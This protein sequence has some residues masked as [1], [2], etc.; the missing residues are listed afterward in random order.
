MTPGLLT[1][2]GGIGLFLFGMQTMTDALRQLASTQAR[3]V[4]ARFTRTPASGALTGALTTAA[5]QSSTATMVTTVGFVGAGLLS[6]SQALGIIF[7]ASVGTTVTGWMV[8]F[9]G[10]RLPLSAAAL[11]VLFAAALLRVL[12]NGQTARAALAVAGLC[13]V[14]LGIDLMQTGMEAYEGRL[15]PADFPPASFFGRLQLVAIGIVVTLITQSSS[16]GVAGTLVL[17]AGGAVSFEQAAALVIGMHVGTTFTALL[18]SVG[19]SLAVRRTAVANVVYHVASGAIALLFIDLVAAGLARG[20]LFGDSQIGL[21]VFHTGFNLIGTAVM[22]PITAQFAALIERMIPERLTASL[23]DR[24]DPRLLGEAGAALDTAGSVLREATDR[25]FTALADEMGPEPPAP[26]AME[27]VRQ[28]LEPVLDAMQDYLGRIEVDRDRV[29]DLQ[30]LDALLQQHDHLRRLHARAAQG[31]RIRAL[32]RQERL[33]RHVGVFRGCL[34]RHVAEHPEGAGLAH[35]LARLDGRLER[36]EA[37]VRHT[38]LR[39]PAYVMG[40]TTADVFRLADALRWMR[41]SLEHAARII[42][43][44]DVAAERLSDPHPEAATGPEPSP[45]RDQPSS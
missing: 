38:T 39:R 1:L 21:V 24:L 23:A 14:F 8:L 27:S 35:R 11:P 29:R 6:F 10:F 28:D 15:S 42:E 3:Q 31:A 16:A 18:A 30:R 20:A 32:M 2:V 13:L 36:I 5:I 7:G 26:G 43:Y 4:L 37:R 41:R 45:E 12:S 34:L 9:L 44:D 22:L 40:L 33:S 25:L 17:L 19:G